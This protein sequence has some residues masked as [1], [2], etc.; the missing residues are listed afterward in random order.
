MYNQ[1]IYMA[2]HLGWGSVA[3][4]VKIF[5]FYGNFWEFEPVVNLVKRSVVSKVDRGSEM[6]YQPVSPVSVHS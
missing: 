5:L 4:F 2:M 3:Q 6:W 1:L